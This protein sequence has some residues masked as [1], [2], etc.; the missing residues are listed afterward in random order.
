MNLRTQARALLIRT[1]TLARLDELAL[2]VQKSKASGLIVGV[3]ETPASL[4]SKFRDQ[5]EWASQNFTITTLEIFA[6]LWSDSPPSQ[7]SSKPLLLFTFDDGRESNYAVAAP[8]LESFGGRG[9]FFVVPAFA[10][11]APSQSLSFYRT[12]INPD[13]R[14]GDEQWEDWKP[15]NPTQIADL[16][17]RGHAIGNHT[18]THRRLVGL[19]S[20]KLEQEIGDSARKLTA[21]TQKPVD[22]FAWTFGWDAVDANAWEVI[23]RYHRF[24]FAPCAGIIDRRYDSPS[25]LWRRE[26]E[27]KYSA[28]EYRFLYSGLVDPWWSTRRRLLGKMLRLS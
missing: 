8:L 17:A 5:L 11:C 27:V 24:C 12:N 21:W 19:S 3:H 6:K 15:M 1:A 4:E 18:L 16:A 2:R 22:A 23:R 9:V 28:P 26:I 7:V 14:P 13:S 25:L 10:E 20:D